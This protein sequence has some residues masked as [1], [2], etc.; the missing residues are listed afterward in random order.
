MI[1]IPAV[2]IKDGRCV[3]LLQGRMDAETIFSDDPAAMAKRWEQEGAEV[4]HV[5]DLDGAV[6]KSPR[7][8]DAI[9]KIIDGVHVRVQVGGGIRN[10]A[11]V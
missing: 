7:N 1:I 6:E 4:I 10:E 3:R 11:T 9:R 5:V 2:D 8:T